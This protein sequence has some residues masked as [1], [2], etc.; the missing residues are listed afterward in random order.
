[1]KKLLT[2]SMN[3]ILD[4]IGD[5]RA[6]IGI[7][8]GTGLC[9]SLE[10]KELYAIDYVNIPGFVNTN[11]PTHK[12]KMVFAQL[13]E[14]NVVIMMG[15]FHYYEG[16]SMEEITYPIHVL[17]EMG[18][19]K[20]ILTNAVG[21]VN[22]KY[23]LGDIVVVKDHIYFA[24]SPLRES[25]KTKREFISMQ[26]IYTDVLLERVSKE[27]EC[28]NIPI[29]FGTYFYMKGPQFETPAE[30][31]AISILGG[32]IVGMSTIPEVIVASSFKMEILCLS[33]VSNFAAKVKTP[34]LDS[35]EVINTAR[36]YSKRMEYIVSKI[37]VNIE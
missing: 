37:V 16:Y 1:M 12:G 32:D 11:A 27:A 26:N 5:F 18:I 14:R 23:K 36:F 29:H 24:E 20:L 19:N 15:R 28:Q 9:D 35:L 34:N 25:F 17:N 6:E 7:I 10:Y 3:Y 4:I 31:N 8:I 33:M 2:E 22:P 21:A 13:G 30:I